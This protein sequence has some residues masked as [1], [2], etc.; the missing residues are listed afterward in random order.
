MGNQKEILDDLPSSLHIEIALHLHRRVLRKVP[1]FESA[2]D[3][4]LR[5]LV[6][7]LAPQVCIPGETILRR[8]QIGHQIYFI[9]KGSVEVLGPDE[10]T[11]IATLRDGAFF[12]EMALL[13]SQPRANTVIAVD[14]CTLYTL[15]RERFDQ[16]LRD[17]PEFAA[18]VRSIAELRRNEAQPDP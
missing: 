14:Y 5:E 15:E 17:F 9:N 10:E 13:T 6:L 1:L 2:S 16:V 12:G 8:G 11:V 3:T 18:Q 7:H 4:F